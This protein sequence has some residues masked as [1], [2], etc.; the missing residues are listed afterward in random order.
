MFFNFKSFLLRI[1]KLNTF[2]FLFIFLN[3]FFLMGRVLAESSLPNFVLGPG[4]KIDIKF[5]KLENF[6]TS[7]EILPD[8]TVNL[9]RVGTIFLGGYSLDK[10]NR[11]MTE[12]Y[13]KIIKRPLIYINLLKIRPVNFSISGE[14]KSP[15]LYSLS[16][17]SETGIV[18]NNSNS[19]VKKINYSGWPS[20]VT[21]IQ[22]A[23][24]LNQRADIKNIQIKRKIKGNFE[25]IKVD[26]WDLIFNNNFENNKLIFYGDS[27]FI[28]RTSDDSLNYKKLISKTNLAPLN[29]NINVV[30]EVYNPGKYSILSNS[31]ASQG[32]LIAGGLKTTAS[33]N[34]R[35]VRLNENGTIEI[36]KFT[37]DVEK[38][39]KK[40]P[41]LQDGDV[42]VVKGNVLKR[43]GDNFENVVKP[44]S[45]ISRALF[46]Y[47]QF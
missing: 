12:Y 4:D 13:S 19:S 31:P 2:L 16:S 10:A 29:I 14:I 45:P 27:I 30:G 38:G 17:N 39:Q 9:P 44:L 7:T 5:Y 21:A 26:L 15:G 18:S 11:I 22:K 20:I 28:S 35:L 23:G 40:L 41:I 32:I 43:F 33:K 36:K 34:L 24:G 42:L 6:N 8:G 3:N 46:L 37:Y 1:P 25:I 47:D